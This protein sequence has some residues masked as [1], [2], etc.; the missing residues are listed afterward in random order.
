MRFSLAEV[1][2]RAVAA[3]AAIDVIIAPLSHSSHFAPPPLP[4]SK[5]RD[6]T[7][8]HT[9][10]RVRRQSQVGV[11]A[12]ASPRSCTVYLLHYGSATGPALI[13]MLLISCIARARAVCLSAPV[14]VMCAL[15]VAKVRRSASMA[16]QALASTSSSSIKQRGLGNEEKDGAAARS[17][18]AT[19]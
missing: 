12:H 18:R 14:H 13:M 3:A 5:R 17:A 2:V 8:T 1:S 15:S 10:T 16:C 4:P 9:R 6:T 7:H 19:S 11:H